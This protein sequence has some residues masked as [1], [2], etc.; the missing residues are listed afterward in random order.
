[1]KDYKYI[2]ESLIDD[3]L[4]T[5]LAKMRMRYLKE[6]T[7]FRGQELCYR[8]F[9][10]LCCTNSRHGLLRSPG[11]ALGKLPVQDGPLKK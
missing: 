10:S 3:S 9:G 6:R 11:K 8:F 2:Y 7:F 1:M 5:K 4:F